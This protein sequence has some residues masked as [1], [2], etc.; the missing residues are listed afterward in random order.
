LIFFF[1]IIAQ[2]L[3]A[4][5]FNHLQPFLARLFEMFLELDVIR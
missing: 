4:H 5:S 1:S 3:I 2:N